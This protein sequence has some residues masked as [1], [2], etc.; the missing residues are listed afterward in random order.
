VVDVLNDPAGRG[1]L[2]ALGIRS[3][4]AV[5]RGSDYVLA[6]NLEEVAKF[7]GLENTGHHPLPPPVLYE[8]MIKILRTAQRCIRQIPTD[9]MRTSA[10]HNRDRPLRSLSH[11]VFCI[12]E[13]HLKCALLGATYANNLTS[14]SLA[15]GTFESG[16]EI[17]DY[18]E[19]II[20][21]LEQ[22]WA[23]LEDKSC[24]QQ[25][26]TFYGPIS[27]HE[28]LERSTWHPAQHTRQLAAVL[29]QMGIEP[30]GRLSAEDLAGLPLP[31][32]LWE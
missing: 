5:A 15:D 10:T 29:E 23:N 3:I 22:W 1:R 7:I 28:L 19:E 31:E 2:A 27:L 21:R 6:A 12:G 25:I 20:N 9:K 8:R 14:S 17:S 11:H 32:R 26:A 24:G 4:P 18:G 30:E 13:A 16:A